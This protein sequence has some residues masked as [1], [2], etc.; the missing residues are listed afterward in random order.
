[1]FGI[2]LLGGVVRRLFRERSRAAALEGTLEGIADA[3][4]RIIGER[5]E[6]PSD[7]MAAPLI[8][9]SAPAISPATNGRKRVKA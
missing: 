2:D 3:L 5:P 1:M 9:A 8:E 7:L 6:L 4:E